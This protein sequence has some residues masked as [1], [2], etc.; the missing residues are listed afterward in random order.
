[1]HGTNLIAALNTHSSPYPLCTPPPLPPY[2]SL[3][4]PTTASTESCGDNNGG[5]E[6]Q[7]FPQPP[8]T[9]VFASHTDWVTGIAVAEDRIM[10][11][12][13][14]DGTLKLW[15]LAS[16]DRAGSGAVAG[17]VG[18]EGQMAEEG[19]A[20]G[21][22]RGEGYSCL[23]LLPGFLGRSSGRFFVLVCVDGSV[24]QQCPCLCGWD[25]SRKLQNSGH[26]PPF[27]GTRFR[28]FYPL[29][30]AVLYVSTR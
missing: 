22:E 20:N 5:N 25:G 16:A 6:E 15:D 24:I 4:C 30:P 12:A 19:E 26:G 1:M 13:S 9:G 2:A 27:T 3:P 8:C 11:S 29:V 28:L 17:T 7:H 14:Y 21:G 23:G 10:A 18:A